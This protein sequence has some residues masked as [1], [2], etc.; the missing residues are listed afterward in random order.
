MVLLDDVLVE[1]LGLLAFG[2]KVQG[3]AQAFE[4]GR[5]S[6]SASTDDSVEMIGKIHP[7]TIKVATDHRHVNNLANWALGPLGIEADSRSRIEE[8]D[9][10]RS[11][12]GPRHL[13]ETSGARLLQVLGLGDIFGIDD[14]TG[15][16]RR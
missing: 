14:S 10:E 16:S 2:W 1:L 6:R 7:D 13:D 11:E 9:L 15:R 3:V 5:F 8:C 12:I 4:Q